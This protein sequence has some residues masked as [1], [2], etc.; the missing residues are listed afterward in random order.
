MVRVSERGLSSTASPKCA[1]AADPDQLK[2][3]REDIKKLLD[4]SLCHPILVFSINLNSAYYASDFIHF[5]TASISSSICFFL[6]LPF[7]DFLVWINFSLLK[8]AC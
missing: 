6:F 5:Q 4:T 7:E 8:I 1:A 3:A 2:S